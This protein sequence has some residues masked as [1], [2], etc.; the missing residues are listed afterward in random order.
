LTLDDVFELGQI[1]KTHGLKGQMLF[2]IDVDEPAS[3]TGTKHLLINMAG[4]LVPFFVAGWA[5][6]RSASG[7]QEEV[8]LSLEGITGVDAAQQ[9][10]GEKA[11]LST[12]ELAPLADGR[13][14]FH[15][16]VGAQV[17]DDEHGAIGVVESVL[18][19]PQQLILQITHTSGKEILMPLNDQTLHAFDR[20][21]K[22]VKTAMPPG[23]MEIYLEE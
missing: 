19:M 12:S 2:I 18:E 7:N 3:Y 16:L 15:E 6:R 14:Y 17:I 20:E 23:L 13:Y 11:Y 8:I 21:A 1:V 10:V 5:P 22:Q 9:L 4:R